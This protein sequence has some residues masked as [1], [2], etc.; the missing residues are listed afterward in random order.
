[1]P[2]E[3]LP[4][5]EES[6][7]QMRKKGLEVAI[8]E[9]KSLLASLETAGNDPRVKK[10]LEPVVKGYQEELARLEAEIAGEGNVTDAPVMSPTLFPK[11]IKDSNPAFDFSGKNDAL[12][13]SSAQNK[14]QQLIDSLKSH[15]LS[16]GP[17][18]G[19][20][21]NAADIIKGLLEGFSKGEPFNLPPKSYEPEPYP[22]LTEGE[23]AAEI[24][25]A[26]KDRESPR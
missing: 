23:K 16:I 9:V 3:D 5:V 19:L 8:K 13:G 12:K 21:T 4:K 1:M 11:T 26:K 24:E 7:K 15:T 18:G 2:D 22:R 14:I 25:K 17:K 10:E 20:E 6:L